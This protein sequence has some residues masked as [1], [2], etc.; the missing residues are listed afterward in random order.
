RAT[1]FR[2]GFRFRAAGRRI[3]LSRGTLRSHVLSDL[4]KR[5]PP[6][7]NGATEVAP[8][9]ANP[10]LNNEPVISSRIA[11]NHGASELLRPDPRRSSPKPESRSSGRVMTLI[12]PPAGLSK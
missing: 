9:D 5:N 7:R 12:F 2:V 4:R 6:L 1:R 11:E 8:G 10:H 3:P